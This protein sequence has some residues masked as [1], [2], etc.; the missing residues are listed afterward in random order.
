MG[1]GNLSL[2][3]LIKKHKN[4]SISLFVSYLTCSEIF[5]FN[6]FSEKKG[7]SMELCYKRQVCTHTDIKFR[8]KDL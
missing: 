3:M 1:Q 5:V 2:Y 6:S 8:T 7:F 4:T